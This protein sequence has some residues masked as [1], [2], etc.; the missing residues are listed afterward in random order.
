MLVCWTA[1]ARSRCTVASAGRASK[2]QKRGVCGTSTGT[3]GSLNVLKIRVFIFKNQ[4]VEFEFFHKKLG[5][6]FF[7]VSFHSRIPFR[8]TCGT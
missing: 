4:K 2:I 3:S 6:F 7:D 8:D 1:S 5:S